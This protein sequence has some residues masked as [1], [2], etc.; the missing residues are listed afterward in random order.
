MPPH[1]LCRTPAAPVRAHWHYFSHALGHSM[2]YRVHAKLYV[3]AAQTL[4]GMSIMM[5]RTFTRLKPA[6]TEIPGTRR[7]R[8]P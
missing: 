5:H 3:V 8:C 1:L 2:F 4:S 6:T 7:A